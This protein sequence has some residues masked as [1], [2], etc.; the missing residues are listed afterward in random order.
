[1]ATQQLRRPPDSSGLYD[2]LELILDRGLVIDAYVRVSLVGIELLT[3]DLRVVVASVDTYL[4]YAEA[5]ERL[6]WHERERTPSAGLPDMVGD[7]MTKRAIDRGSRQV[8]EALTGRS[9]ANGHKSNGHGLSSDLAS[10]ARTAA[11][12]TGSAIVRGAEKLKHSLVGEH[13]EES[14]RDEL[15]SRGEAEL[16]RQQEQSQPEQSEPE[17]Q[18]QP[19][20]PDQQSHEEHQ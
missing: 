19:A 18:D 14:P 12:A 15:Q 17:H 20:P 13:E 8:T 16:S 3:V 10:G 11:E 2:V 1:M 4:R 9:S 5:M 6:G 7:G